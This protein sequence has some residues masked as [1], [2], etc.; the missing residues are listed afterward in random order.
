MD[1]AAILDGIKIKVLLVP[2]GA[3]PK[4]KFETYCRVIRLHD[5]V[6]LSELTPLLTN[7]TISSKT[8]YLLLFLEHFT[9]S[10]QLTR[11]IFKTNWVL[12]KDLP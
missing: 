12:R 5:Q 11:R 2:L 3:I 1:A 7:S 6:D 10:C 8:L 4:D 9:L